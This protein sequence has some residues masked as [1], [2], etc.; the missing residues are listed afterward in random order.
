MINQVLL[1]TSANDIISN[2]RGGAENLL[3]MISAIFLILLVLVIACIGV[4]C[5]FF[6]EEGRSKVKKHIF[7]IIGGCAALGLC[8]TIAGFLSTLFGTP[9]I[10]S[11]T[12]SMIH[13]IKSIYCVIRSL[14]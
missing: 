10:P 2:I 7:W 8:G 3:S 13:S 5:L 11:G 1:L 6:G 9:S 4:M 12:E 14:I